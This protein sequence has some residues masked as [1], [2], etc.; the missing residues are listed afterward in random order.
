MEKNNKDNN[1]KNNN[2]SNTW[3]M[4]ADKNIKFLFWPKDRFNEYDR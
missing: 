4:A 3:P 2:S 1:N